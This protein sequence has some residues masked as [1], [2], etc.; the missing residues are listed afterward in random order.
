ML[1]IA[2]PQEPSCFA[3]MAVLMHCV[4]PSA[5]LQLYGAQRRE[6]GGVQTAMI[7]AT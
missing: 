3:F 7:T 2:I 6:N 1:Y 4:T 5:L